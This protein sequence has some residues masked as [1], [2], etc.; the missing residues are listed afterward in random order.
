MRVVIYGPNALPCMHVHAEGCSDTKRG[1][2]KRLDASGEKGWVID[3]ASQQDIVFDI[4][5]PDN[6]DYEPEEWES[7]LN[8]VRIF[9]CVSLPM[10]AG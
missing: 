8:E 7:Y 5:P 3:A 1:V 9:P 6:F 2:Y 4:Y 10:V